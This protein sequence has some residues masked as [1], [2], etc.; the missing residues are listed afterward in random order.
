M[1]YFN[2]ILPFKSMAS[3]WSLPFRLPNQ[4]FFYVFHTYIPCV[5]H[6]P[7]TSFS[8]CHSLRIF[9]RPSTL[10][11]YTLSKNPSFNVPHKLFVQLQRLWWSRGSVLAFS[12]QVRGFKP[13]R[14]RRIFRAKKSS[15]RLPSEGK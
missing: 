12:T 14:I 13:G 9:P 7:P 8:F 5:P 15:P 3:K 11:S 1:T 10:Y 6:A 4:N 2:I